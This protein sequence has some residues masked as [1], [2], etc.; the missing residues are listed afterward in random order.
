M[1]LILLKITADLENLTE[2]QP[3][4]GCDDPNFP[5]YLQMQCMSCGEKS[6]KETCVILS[7]TVPLS[8]GRGTTNLNQKCKFCSREGTMTMIPGRGRPLTLENGEG[9][10]YTPLMVFECRGLEP[11]GFSFGGGWKAVS[12]SGTMFEDIDLSGGDYSEYC[13]KGEVPVM[14]SNLK[15]AFQTVK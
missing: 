3:Q 1:V 9:G 10:Q 14:V 15:A 12:T 6:P 11:V 13:E 5:Y 2:L 7:E 4:G 8:N